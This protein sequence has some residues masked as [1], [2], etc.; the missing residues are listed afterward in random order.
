MLRLLLV[1]FSLLTT[2]Y[3]STSPVQVPMMTSNLEKQKQTPHLPITTGR[4]NHYYIPSPENSSHPILLKLNTLSTLSQPHCPRLAAMRISQSPFTPGSLTFAALPSPS[5]LTSVFWFQTQRAGVSLPISS[6]SIS[7]NG[8]VFEKAKLRA[9][10]ARI[11]PSTPYITVPRSI[12]ETL[13]SATR[14]YKVYH[15]DKKMYEYVV[16][17]DV[18]PKCPVIVIDFGG[19][20][21]QVGAY[22]YALQAPD[23]SEKCVLLVRSEDGEAGNGRRGREVVL[24]GAFLVG[25]LV[26]LDFEYGY[27]GIAQW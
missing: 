21:I 7:S 13:V 17:C 4:N 5:D 9:Y 11:D 12:H 22:R 27:T 6:L 20:E 3:A 24:G 10:T 14:A 16:D 8:K 2:T 1:G 15:S 25:R 19:D 23:G 26:V 18:R